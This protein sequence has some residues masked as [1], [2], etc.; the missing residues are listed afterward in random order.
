LLVSMPFTQ[1]LKAATSLSQHMPCHEHSASDHHPHGADCLHELGDTSCQC[2]QLQVPPGIGVTPI[3]PL[4]VRL[5]V[6]K[7]SPPLVCGLP[8][9]P[10]TSLYR[11]PIRNAS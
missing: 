1:V 7:Q 6:S 8:D 10:R 9:P 11:P 5:R 2:C 3:P 4:P